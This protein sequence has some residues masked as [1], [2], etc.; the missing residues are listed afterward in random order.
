MSFTT[1]YLS[2]FQSV[3]DTTFGTRVIV[4]YT[5]PT[6]ITFVCHLVQD[7]DRIDNITSG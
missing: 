6:M 1:F 2:L 5:M 3:P 7:E 4:F